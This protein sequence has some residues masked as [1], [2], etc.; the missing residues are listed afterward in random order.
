MPNGRCS[1]CISYGVDCTY[2]AV[3]VRGVILHF[4]DLTNSPLE[5]TP[6]EEVRICLVRTV[7]YNRLPTPR[8]YR[9]WRPFIIYD[10]YTSSCIYLDWADNSTAMLRFLRADFRRW[11]SWS[12]R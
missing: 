4:G 3:N 7:G 10:P 5:T 11:R 12:I 8:K 6:Y 2:E 1:K 9:L